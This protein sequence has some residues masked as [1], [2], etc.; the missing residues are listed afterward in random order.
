MVQ[1][2]TKEVPI[3]LFVAAQAFQKERSE[4]PSLK[5]LIVL[6]TRDATW[7]REIEL[8]FPPFP[9]LGIRVDVYKVLN[10]RSV[11]VGDHG[12]EVTCIVELEDTDPN[13]VTQ[14]MCEALGFEVGPYP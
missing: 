9:G 8:P 6:P 14:E 10:V 5:A 13:D 1:I 2:A 7:V 4:M 3:G 12:Y 11:V